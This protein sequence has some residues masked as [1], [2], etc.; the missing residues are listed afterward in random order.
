MLVVEAIRWALPMSLRAR[1]RSPAPECGVHNCRTKAESRSLLLSLKSQ[2]WIGKRLTLHRE[3]QRRW[4]G[5]AAT[6]SWFSPDGGPKT[7]RQSAKAQR[8]AE[9]T[10]ES[11]RWFIES[12]IDD[13]ELAIEL[14]NVR[15][16]MRNN[17]FSSIKKLVTRCGISPTKTET[18][19]INRRIKWA[20][21]YRQQ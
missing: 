17:V 4:S 12:F 16:T 8:R 20:N 9:I 7:R 21:H 14:W 15:D 18:Y 1:L 11:C 13:E 10:N 6:A 2:G 5:M 3:S 19:L